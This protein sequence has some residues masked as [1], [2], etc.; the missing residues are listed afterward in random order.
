VRRTVVPGDQQSQQHAA[1]HHDDRLTCPPSFGDVSSC[2]VVFGD[3]TSQSVAVGFFMALIGSI[4][5]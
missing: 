2:D 3:V 5:T 4:P 1:D